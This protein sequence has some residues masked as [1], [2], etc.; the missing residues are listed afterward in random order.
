MRMELII[1]LVL[2]LAIISIVDK[3]YARV[4]FRQL[5]SDLGVFY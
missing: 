4:E 1:T 5:F 3:L 2:V